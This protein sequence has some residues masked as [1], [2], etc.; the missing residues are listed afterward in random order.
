MKIEKILEY[1]NLDREMFGKEK[2]LKENEN[3]KKANS[4]YDDMKTAQER[5]YKLENKAGQILAEIEKVKKQYQ[6]QEDKMN[7]FLSKNLESISK[8]EIAKLSQLK[9]KLSQNI[10]ILEKNLASLAESMNGVLSEFN[11]AI[12]TINSSK[13]EYAMHKKAYDEDVVQ[14]E[15]EKEKIAVKLKAL[16]ADIDPKIMEEYTKR[17]KENVFPVVVPLR[18]NSCG[19][20]HVELPFAN[21]TKLN[22][23]G[24]LS[25]EHC[26][27][28]IYKA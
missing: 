19:G 1:Q 12:K 27:R 26:R 18:G 11:K 5:S 17:R 22:E 13:E 21:L 28:L 2:E 7:E 14:V 24:M 23:E 15:K 8:D 25:C 10:Q 6:I 4:L 20:C 16:S 9:D 3:K